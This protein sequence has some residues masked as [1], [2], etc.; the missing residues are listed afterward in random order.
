MAIKTVLVDDFDGTPL[1]SGAASTSFS[2]NGVSY[3]IDLGAENA[4]RLRDALAPFIA[5]ARRTGAAP[6]RAKAARAS[7]SDPARLAAIREWARGNGHA[8]SDRGRIAASVVAA[9]DAAH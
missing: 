2:L 8:V 3:E 5:A 1:P 6:A 4:Q 7:G 9:Y